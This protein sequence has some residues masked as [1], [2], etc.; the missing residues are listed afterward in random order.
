VT[1]DEPDTDGYWG[2]RLEMKFYVRGANGH[3]EKSAHDQ[4]SKRFN[5]IM[6]ERPHVFY[7]VYCS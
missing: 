2:R 6:R 4:V 5:E 3:E 7:R 1:Y